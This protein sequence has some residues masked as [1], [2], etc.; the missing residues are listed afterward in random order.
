MEKENSLK[1]KAVFQ[2]FDFLVMENEA[3]Q[4]ENFK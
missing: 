2:W 1:I 3:I 4:M